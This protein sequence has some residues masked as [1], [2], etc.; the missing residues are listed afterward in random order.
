[1]AE[2]A[3]A[4]FLLWDREMFADN[5][6]PQWVQVD[7]ESSEIE[8][9]A[10]TANIGHEHYL[11]PKPLEET[12]KLVFSGKGFRGNCFDYVRNTVEIL[13]Q[14]GLRNQDFERILAFTRT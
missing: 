1:M 10:F 6:I 14:L 4:C 9:L 7:T 12:A 3:R 5:Y 11:P 13:Q 8:A 2:F